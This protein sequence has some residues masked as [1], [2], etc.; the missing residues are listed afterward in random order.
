MLAIDQKF[1][2]KLGQTVASFGFATA[3]MSVIGYSC[4]Q[5]LNATWTALGA[6]PGMALVG[7]R[8]SNL[9]NG[10]KR[11]KL[12]G[13]LDQGHEVVLNDQ[14]ITV[15]Q[16]REHLKPWTRPS[17]VALAW[18]HEE[19]HWR[20]IA[21]PLTAAIVFG[22]S[23]MVGERWL[24]RISAALLGFR[25]AIVVTYLPSIFILALRAESSVSEDE[26]QQFREW[27]RDRASGLQQLCMKAASTNNSD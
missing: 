12:L 21:E 13:R 7:M 3:S 9:A 26:F 5:R 14:P 23:R 17:S 18:V 10:G 24:C 8:L 6:I 19:R 2:G 25:A 15:G 22:F 11:Y 4:W 1:D 27:Y 16:I 20:T